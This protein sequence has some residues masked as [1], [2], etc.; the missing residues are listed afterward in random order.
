M[1]KYDQNPRKM[2]D[3]ARCSVVFKKMSDIYSFLQRLLE[4]EDLPVVR[5]KD[6][7]KNKSDGGYRDMLVNV[8]V[9]G[10]DKKRYV[11]EVQLHHKKCYDLKNGPGGSHKLY[12]LCREVDNLMEKIRDIRAT[13]PEELSLDELMVQQKV[14][15]KKMREVLA[16]AR[17]TDAKNQ[18]NNKL[19]R[20]ELT[21]KIMAAR[22]STPAPKPDCEGKPEAHR[23][24][25]QTRSA[26]FYLP[27]HVRFAIL[28]AAVVAA[29]LVSFFWSRQ[30]KI[31][32]GRDRGY[33]A[34]MSKIL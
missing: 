32:V 23:R 12:T 15:K 13:K 9:E 11:C 7:F 6:R 4:S 10:A 22:E 14:Q 31:P 8:S 27:G 20:V 3:V 26:C 21:A 28:A 5:V 18:F 2:T 29:A 1:T 16:R 25:L 34:I 33:T 30:A 24:R 17:W 19:R